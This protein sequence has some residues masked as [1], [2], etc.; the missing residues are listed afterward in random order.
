MQKVKIV[1]AVAMLIDASSASAKIC[2]YRLSVLLG[3]Q[4]A[5][6]A[7]ATELAVAWAGIGLKAAGFYTLTNAATGSVMLASTAGGV[8]GAG[9]VGIM[10]G[11]AGAVGTGASVLMSPVVIGGTILAAVGAG[12]MEAVCYYQDDRIT[13]FDQV[14]KML[15]SVAQHTDPKQFRLEVPDG[16]V[17]ASRIFVANSDGKYDVYNVT[18]LYIV[19]GV[20]W[21]SDWFN[22][23]NV[24]KIGFLMP[25]EAKN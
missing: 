24:G 12:A 5:G 7:T 14:F 17:E 3:D 21:N 10:G 16:A 6:A 22:D 2:D 19:N 1:I 11:T 8:S 15:Q 18:D 23:T 4:G 20:L 9:T 13:D 25:K